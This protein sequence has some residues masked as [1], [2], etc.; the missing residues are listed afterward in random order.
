MSQPTSFLERFLL[1]ATL[2]LLVWLP[3]PLG[4]NRD[5]SMGLF[6]CLMGGVGSLWAVGQLRGAPAQGLHSKAVKLGLPMLGLLLLSQAWVALQWLAG[7][8]VDSGSTFQYLVLGLSYCLLFVLVLSQFNTRKRLNLLLVTLIASGTLQAFHGAFMTLSGVEWLL[9]GPKTSYLGDA[10]GTFVNRNHLA[11]YLEMTLAC[12]IGLLL[13]LRDG[14]PF[15]LINLLELLMGPKA[16]LRLA[17]VVMVI[18]LVMTHSRMGNTAF[19]ASLLMVGTLFVLLEKKHRLRNGLILASIILIDVLVISQYFGL[20]K[21]KDR[22]LNTRLNDVVVN[23]EVV[24]QANEVRDD[25]FNY[26]IPLLQER[27]L[28]GQGAGSFEAVYPKYP[29]EDIRIHFDHAHNDYIQFAIEFGLLGSLP[30]AAFVLMALW[31]ALRALWRRE[32]VYRSGVGFGAAMGIIALLI[33]SS[34][35]FNLQIPA[36]AATLVVL[37]AIAILA[38]S[39]SNPRTRQESPQWS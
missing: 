16:R 8:S 24:Q 27:P 7:L 11:G 4:S 29:G 38:N 17:L 39:H 3:L 33:H 6:V 15:N 26:A 28:L 1:C 23:G 19:F 35:D 34:T 14:R 18:A 9:A 21:L 20:E 2:F 32:S 10:T 37:C 30:L 36:N 5:W 25:V 31:H 12:G 13:A 22:V